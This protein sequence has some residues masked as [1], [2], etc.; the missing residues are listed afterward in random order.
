MIEMTPTQRISLNKAIE[1]FQRLLPNATNIQIYK[2]KSRAKRCM[3]G[4]CYDCAN[5]IDYSLGNY[6]CTHHHRFRRAR[7]TR[8]RLQ[9][10]KERKCNACGNDLIDE[11]TSRCNYCL[12]KYKN[13]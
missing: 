9:R 11:E 12:S 6:V 7:Y 13:F 2:F 8:R 5:P 1:N 4:I 3:L 10:R